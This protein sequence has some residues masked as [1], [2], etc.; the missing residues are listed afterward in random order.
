MKSQDLNFGK[1][2][3]DAVKS[4]NPDDFGNALQEYADAVQESVMHDVEGKI[5]EKDVSI[6]KARGKNDLTENERK[7]YDALR[8]SIKTKSPIKMAINPGSYS[9]TMPET[10]I[11]H[12]FDDLEQTHPLLAAMNFQNTTGQTKM[13]FNAAD[14]PVAAWGELTGTIANELAGE[15]LV[16]T[17]ELSKLSSFIPI[18]IAMIDVGYERLDQYVRTL[19]SESIAYGCEYGAIKGTGKDMPIGMTKQVGAGVSVTGGVY[20]D[21]PKQLVADFDA[22][23]LGGLVAKI[24]QKGKRQ[25]KQL[26]LVV[27][28]GDY[29]SKIMPATTLM[30]PSGTYVSNV[31]PIPDIQIIPSTQM[32][33]GKAV[34]GDLS[35]YFFGIGAGTNGGRME[36][37]DQYQFLEDNRVYKI[38]LY[39][40]GKALDN[41][42]FQ[43]LDI[44][45]LNP[46]VYSFKSLA[47]TTTTETTTSG[48]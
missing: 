17:M 44:S 18:P 31:L 1:K 21:K 12:I 2:I 3:A 46:L 20:P 39:G 37:S 27:N 7:F 10:L 40:A 24:T 23:T 6:L 8:E 15:F 30:S 19:L 36:Y 34:I 28:A 43:M 42:A 29:F 48:D 11:D 47:T 41:D 13:Y 5:Q 45:K 25:A 14:T 33:A 35:K 4:G 16:E 32:D 26:A 9:N 38:K 22:K